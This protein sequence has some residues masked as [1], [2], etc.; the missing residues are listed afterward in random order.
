MTPT[1][2][3]HSGTAKTIGT[4]MGSLGCA[5]LAFYL[6][7]TGGS[8][9]VLWL[10]AVACG[11]GV[12]I[13]T[14]RP[15]TAACAALVFVA[16]IPI[17]WTPTVPGIPVAPTPGVISLVVLLPAAWR[18]RREWRLTRLDAAVSAYVVLVCLSYA[19]NSSGGASGILKTIIGVALPYAVFRLIVL[20]K[21]TLAAASLTLVIVGASLAVAAFSERALG[22]NPFFGVFPSGFESGRWERAELRFG[23]IRAETGFGHPLPFAMFLAFVV[24]IALALMVGRA[25]TGRR[26]ALAAVVALITGGLVA[27]ATRGP[28]L[29][30]GLALLLWAFRLG[31]RRGSAALMSALLI[32]TATIALSAAGSAA[33]RI[34]A[35]SLDPTSPAARSA[36]F[37]LYLFDLVSRPD[38]FSVLGQPSGERDQGITATVLART[39]LRSIDNEFA[40][41]YLSFGAVALLALALAAVLTGWV[42]LG[43]GLDPLERAWAVG[44]F[45]AFVGLTFVALLTQYAVLFWYAVGATSAISQTEHYAHPF[46]RNRLSQSSSREFAP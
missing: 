45:A 31:V 12:W 10:A 14:H 41:V 36:A 13:G 42:A 17:Y 24:V 6:A 11:V 21:P 16:V 32:V 20:D 15:R 9:A 29:V 3:V 46:K 25:G 37:R 26:V 5:A 33:D 43:A 18:Y 7:A 2:L 1:T 39:N 44:A 8:L 35:D 19:V 22:E 34:V 28:V 27:T 30:A 40:L 23:G 4:V 38:Q